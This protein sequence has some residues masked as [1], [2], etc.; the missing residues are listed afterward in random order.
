MS[1][2][3]SIINIPLGLHESKASFRKSLPCIQERHK[4]KRRAGT[5]DIPNLHIIMIGFSF[6]IFF[7]TQKCCSKI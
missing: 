3:N 5:K 1:N 2:W 6:L 7:P 4:V